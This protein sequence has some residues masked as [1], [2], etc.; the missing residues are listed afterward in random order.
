MTH[1]SAL[2]L[3]SAR[4]KGS[5][6]EVCEVNGRHHWIASKEIRKVLPGLRSDV[7]LQGQYPSGFKK[8]DSRARY[9]FN[10]AAL[11]SELQRIG[12][13][14]GLLLLA[15]LER[16]V[17][18]PARRKREVFPAPAMMPPP[19]Q[20]AEPERAAQAGDHDQHHHPP[21]AFDGAHTSATGSA[22]C[23]QACGGAAASARSDSHPL[24]ACSLALSW[25]QGR[26]GANRCH[27]RGGAGLL[28][29]CCAVCAADSD[30]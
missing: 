25:R 17:F 26:A 6:I 27:R 18:Y 2:R 8:L 10:E 14:D 28:D 29:L 1:P 23:H 9:H 3:W 16:T 5:Q 4:Y 11:V 19:V 12:S 20:A 13:Q 30:P 22:S 24:R 7:Q 15:W 21:P